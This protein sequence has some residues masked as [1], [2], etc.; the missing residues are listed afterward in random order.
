MRPAFSLII[1]FFC[2]WA[3]P[4][5]AAWLCDTE[6]GEQILLLEKPAGIYCEPIGEPNARPR[7]EAA[8]AE[9]SCR[10]SLRCWLRRHDMAA[11]KHCSRAVQ[12]LAE[13]GFNWT[14]GLVYS[15]FDARSWHDRFAATISFAGDQIEFRDRDGTMTRQMYRCVYDPMR[16]RVTEV[17][18]VPVSAQRNVP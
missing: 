16:R 6:H 7:D 11:A 10:R 3:S 12:E 9:E 17:D 15:R 1:M 5:S 13:H 4:A 14:D 18:A 2:F 8:E